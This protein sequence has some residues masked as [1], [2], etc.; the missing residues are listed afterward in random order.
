MEGGRKGG[1]GVEMWFEVALCEKFGCGF[2][3]DRWAR[4]CRCIECFGLRLVVLQVP[5]L[6]LDHVWCETNSLDQV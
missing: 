5:S 4:Q 1:L 6:S 3:R 2:D